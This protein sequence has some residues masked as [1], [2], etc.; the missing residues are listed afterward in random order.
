MPGLNQ[1]GPMGEGAMTGR[2]MGKCTNFG[3]KVKKEEQRDVVQDSENQQNFTAFDERAGM[4][5]GRGRRGMGRGLGRGQNGN[6][7]GMGRRRRNRFG[8]GNN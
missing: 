1:K 8:N 2:R 6:S 5:F 7:L 4:G 3:T